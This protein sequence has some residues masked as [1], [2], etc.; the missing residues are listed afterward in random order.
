[1]SEQAASIRLSRTHKG[2]RRNDAVW[3]ARFR[4]TGR[5]TSRVLGKAWTK[6]S[7]PPAGFLTRS[8]AEEAL[9]Q[10][11]L[12]EAGAV[13]A[14]SGATFGEVADA[15][16]AELEGRIQ[17]GS[18]R[19]STLVTY[20]NIIARDLRPRWE[21][22][23]IAGI[24]GAEVA[25]FH[26]EALARGLSASTINQMRAIVHGIFVLAVDR[27]GLDQDVS[28]AFRRAKTRRATSDRI[29]FYSPEEI[30]RLVEAA[31]N[32]QDA[33]LFLTAAFTGLRASELRALRWR[34][35]DGAA[36]LIHVERGYTDEGGEDLPKSYRVRSVP[37]IPQVALALS[38]LRQRELF[39]GE[40][41]LVFVNTIG[42]VLDY[43]K[44]S[45]R[46]R[47]AQQ[48]AGLRP[49]AS[50]TS[51]TASAPWPSAAS[52][53]PTSR[54]GWAT[55]TSPRPASTSTTPPSPRPLPSS[56]RSSGSSWARDRATA[57]Q[58][59]A[60]W[61]LVGSPCVPKRP[62]RPA[63][64]ATSS[65]RSDQYRYMDWPRH[66]RSREAKRV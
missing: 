32:E 23:P 61:P 49:C 2:R 55:P 27:F 48:R 38:R 9:R 36:S 51:A 15:Y 43:D 5:D 58:L 6:R 8:H 12:A 19:A 31:A 26:R 4:I 37:L 17:T 18:F 63:G 16:L 34:S 22:R 59:R 24:T 52:P 41:E 25:A 46:Y 10:L 62:S 13:R 56:A 57:H 33:A 7:Q 66:Q 54:P 21:R 44:L 40:D 28:V 3:I 50:T 11:L 35:V 45:R 30:L 14:S 42:T 65:Q 47:A 60:R 39:T 53:S 20:R 64:P 1:M 29:S